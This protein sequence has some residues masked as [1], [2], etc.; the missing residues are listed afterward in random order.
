MR[1]TASLLAF[2]L[3]PLGA[4]AQV[5][6]EEYKRIDLT[7]VQVQ[8][9]NTSPAEI[10]PPVEGYVYGIEWAIVLHSGERFATAPGTLQLRVPGNSALIYAQFSAAGVLLSETGSPSEGAMA[11]AYALG[12]VDDSSAS[13]GSKGMELFQAGGNPTVSE[14]FPGSDV[15]VLVVYRLL[16]SYISNLPPAN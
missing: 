9:L 15:S 6:T 11:R 5:P 8:A 3:I 1:K 12:R 2:S 13:L 7:N 10:L 16:P 14:A 4:Y